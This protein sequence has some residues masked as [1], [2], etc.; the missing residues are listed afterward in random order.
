ML[1]NEIESL[2]EQIASLTAN[3][4]DQVSNLHAEIARLKEEHAQTVSGIQTSHAQEKT[5]M[6]QDFERRIAELTA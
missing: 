6:E 1:N 3:A 4:G 5:Q 2:R